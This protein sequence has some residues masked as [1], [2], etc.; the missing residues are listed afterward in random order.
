MR[1]V[2]PVNTAADALPAD[3]A[4]ADPHAAAHAL[5]QR[6]L[7]MLNQLAQIG[8]SLAEA[9]ERLALAQVD[10][11]IAS[12]GAP[13]GASAGAL[14]G[15][16]R[17]DPGLTYARVARAV[18]LTLMLQT[19]LLKE[20]PALGRAETLAKSAQEDARRDRAH[21]LAIRAIKVEHDD[22]D[23]VEHL[24]DEAWERLRDEDLSD[25][26]SGRPM[27]EVVARICADLGLSLDWT[28][29]AMAAATATTAP[30][31]ETPF[32]DPPPHDP[33][34]VPSRAAG[35]L[36][37]MATAPP[38]RRR[39]AGSAIPDPPP[40]AWAGASGGRAPAPAVLHPAVE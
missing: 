32:G 18:R 28:A 14:P 38:R 26:I 6:Q 17:A 22:E 30:P 15:A 2:D 27:G 33:S 39:S 4:S 1:H 3:L 20:L 11:A 13:D 24:S 21:R 34:T 31:D 19:R 29:W 25:D 35:A 8:M 9:T 37:A 5:V 23:V 7:H 10:A 12:L 16:F 40:S 36:R